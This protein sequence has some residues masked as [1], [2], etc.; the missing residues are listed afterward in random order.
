MVISVTH[1]MCANIALIIFVSTA[2][3][4]A[5]TAP[6]YAPNAVKSVRIVLTMSFAASADYASHG[7]AGKE[8]NAQT[9]DCGRSV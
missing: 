7:V 6:S 2:V 1:A 9:E 3:E 8:S 5:L 4:D